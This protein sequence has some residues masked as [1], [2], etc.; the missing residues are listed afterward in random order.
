M[1]LI[2]FGARNAILCIIKVK[3]F[4]L[5]KSLCSPSITSTIEPTMLACF[6]HVFLVP[7]LRSTPYHIPLKYSFRGYCCIRCRQVYLRFNW[8]YHKFCGQELIGCILAF[9]DR[10]YSKESHSDFITFCD[11]CIGTSRAVGYIT[12]WRYTYQTLFWFDCSSTWICSRLVYFRT[13]GR[14][15]RFWD[16]KVISFFWWHLFL[17]F[18]PS[19]SECND[20]I[21]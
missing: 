12:Y 8:D 7:L 16:L 13:N 20:A 18:E 10:I 15:V 1:C 4:V 9:T 3:I 11:F 17:I 14:G 5:I 19:T 2:I 6:E 21:K